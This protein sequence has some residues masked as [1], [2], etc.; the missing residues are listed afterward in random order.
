MRKELAPPT[1]FEQPMWLH[2]HLAPALALAPEE[3]FYWVRLSFTC[4]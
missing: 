1:D 2:R 4:Y 3:A